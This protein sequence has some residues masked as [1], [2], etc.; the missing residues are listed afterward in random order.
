MFPLV[1]YFVNRHI[2]GNVSKMMALGGVWPD[3]AAGAGYDRNLAH[4]MGHDFFHWCLEHAPDHLDLARGVISHGNNPQCV[5]YFADED[6][7]GCEKGWC[8]AKGAPYM[9]QVGAATHLPG[10]LLWWK[11]HNFVEMSYELIAAADCPGLEEE[12]LARVEDEAAKRDTAQV[13]AAYTRKPA[14]DIYAMF[15]KIP[16]IFAVR[17]IS[18]EKLAFRQYTAFSIRHNIHDADIPAM[19][20]LLEQMRHELA[21]GYYPFMER[22]LRLTGS[23]LAK[24]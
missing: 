12:L 19:A 11:A 8:F 15:S 6:W 20:A 5:D 14:D 23:A 2:Y 3:L 24:Y 4:Y 13:L 10:H 22:V 17:D 21:S 1:H 18:P 9:P 16:Q 7:P